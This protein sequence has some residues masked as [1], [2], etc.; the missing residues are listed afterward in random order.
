[1]INLSNYEILKLIYNGDKTTVYQAKSN[2]DGKL[3]VIKILNI[4]YPSLK[5]IAKLKYEYDLL[6]NLDIGGVIK[7]YSLEK[8]NNSFALILENFDSISIDSLI[9][10]QQIELLDFLKIAIEITQ[11]IGEVHQ[12]HIIHKDIKPANILVHRQTHQI[13]IIDFSISSLLPKEK[14]KFSNPDSLEGTLTYISPEQTGRMNRSLDYRTDLYSLGVTFYEMLTGKL[15][16]EVTDPMELIHCH[17][18]RQAV[19]VD[20]L[21]PEIPQVISAI[22]MKLLSKTAEERYQSAF[23]LQFDL[24]NC[25]NQLENIAQI[26]SFTIGQHDQSSQLQIPEKLYGREVEIATLLTAF[27]QVNQGQKELILVAGYSGIGKS[28][29]VNE[30]HKPIIQKKGYFITGKFEQF[31][32][33]I[34]YA[35][36]I[37]ALQELIRQLLTESDVQLASWKDK[38][39]KALAP[40]A[41]IIIDVIPEVELIIGKQPAV[42]QLAPNE[43]QNRFNLFFQKFISILAK[44]EHPL[45]LFLDDLQWA[46]LASLKLIQLLSTDT[47]IQNLLIIGAYRDNEV[48]STHPLT[49]TLQEIEK[50]DVIVRTINC[51]PLKITDIYQLIID[52]F[53]C[54]LER[55]KPLAELIFNKTD[56]NPF[57]LTQV[58][59]F[60]YQEN[61]LLFNFSTS[62]WQWKIEQ[63]QEIDITDNVIE[64]MLSKI[65]KLRECT[66]NILKLAACIGNRFNLDVLSVINEKSHQNTA[67]ELWEA[68]EYGLILPLDHTYK[69][70]QF[71]EQ[72]DDFVIDYKF[73]HDRVQQVAYGLI[74]DGRKKESHLKIGQLLLNNL[75]QSLKE[76]KIFDIVNHL[77][78][79]AE[80][81]NSQVERYNLAQLNLIA[82]SKAKDSTA[83]ES[84]VKF[85]NRGLE[86]LATDSWQT[87]YELTL[88][89]YVETIEMEYL[90]TNFEQAETLFDV[91]IQHSKNI[92]DTVKV[93]EKKI[94]SY[95]SQ[96]RMREALD[97]NLQVLEMLGVTL[98]Q[99]PPT[100]LSIEEFA[101]LP[102]MTDPRK[103]AAMRM[104]ITAIP[105]AYFTE[106]TL[107]PL[108]VFTMIELCLKY[109][110]SSLAAHAYVSYGL[111]LIIIPK[112]LRDIELGYQ[113]GK[114]SLH[115]LEQ[116]DTREIKPKSYAVF[117]MFVKHWKEHLK[118]SIEPLQEGFKLGI[119]A[120]DFEYASY[121]GLLFCMHQFFAGENLELLEQNQTPYISFTQKF[122]QDY[123]TFSLKIF[124]QTVSDFIQGVENEAY[125][126][127][128]IFNNSMMPKLIGNNTAT[129]Y[130]YFG[131]II[132]YYFFKNYTQAVN[133]AHLA[134]QYEVGINGKIYIAQYNFY[135]SLALLALYMERSSDSGFEQENELEATL[136]KV[137]VNQEQ[138]QEWAFYAPVNFQHKYDLVEAE[139]AR[140]LGQTLVAMEY[141]DQA[142]RGANNNGYI[143]EEALAY[144]RAAEFYLALG[145]NEFATL[146]IKKAHYGYT[147]WGAIAKVKDLESRYRELISPSSTTNKTHTTEATI[148]VS[149]TSSKTNNLDLITVIK[150][151]Q[152]LSEEILLDELIES[153]MQIVIENAGAETGY[154][155]LEKEGNLFI[156]AKKGVNRNEFKSHQ[157]VGTNDQYLPVSLIKYVERTREYIVISNATS[158]GIFTTDP[159]IIKNQVKSILCMPIVHQGKLIG[160]LYLE[161]TLIVGAFTPNRLQVL[162]IL[163]SQA[164]ISLENARLYANLE[165]KVVERT[166]ELNKNNRKLEET[167]SELKFTQTQLVQTEKMSSLGQMV[168]GVA[169][170]INNPISFIAGNLTHID[171]YV[172]DLLTLIKLYEEVYPHAVP[173]INEYMEKIQLDFLIE[174][175]PK[176]LSSMRNGTQRI[177]EI[178][179]TLRNFSRLD[180][181]DL[182]LVNIHEGIDSTLVI[183]KNRFQANG[184]SS[185]IEIIKNYA[186]LPKVECYAGQLNQV[187]MNILANAIDALN[188]LNQEQRVASNNHQK[189][190]IIS[191]KIVTPNWVT[192]SIKDNGKGMS[193]T[194]KQKIFDPFFTTKPVGEGT[195]LGLSI[196]Y[197]IIVDKHHGKIECISEL[198]EGA[199][200]VIE[201][202]LLQQK[203]YVNAVKQV[204]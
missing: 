47:E 1:M 43:T 121:S 98:S 48:D 165:E 196:S 61:L 19:P 14:P 56:G 184:K 189:T 198:G 146:Y 122:K 17:I 15:P 37:Q 192:I 42:P 108:I 153:L 75:D 181:S 149:A 10:E 49:L 78:I 175:I 134:K 51:Q 151:S 203:Q 90:N 97:I 164:A 29:L 114:L 41:Q 109:G 202:P 143:Q 101:N 147:R 30:I 150:A 201:I 139:K 131:K 123:F 163:S 194:V 32:R 179:L 178:V 154:L 60:I 118:T 124:R 34:P 155:I 110:N 129:F 88:N 7:A 73:L 6:K 104:L 158:D 168:A 127:G 191:T 55:A 186:D 103:L 156:E 70:P 162:K 74:P 46:D 4:D 18:A 125:L 128:E 141:Y 24:E 180:E 86:M 25:L 132:L 26:S 45:V 21:K 204:I 76:E 20:Q 145:R 183:L 138:L 177:S 140:V 169:H 5:D 142:I 59:K 152:A 161:N 130:L 171:E 197:Q 62:N 144:E 115:I 64:L 176:T 79:G 68:L 16:F 35:S 100:R 40:N 57:F 82:G 91:V 157:I 44:K 80:L 182:K 3:V 159:Y 2:E 160:I 95:V 102:E 120:G 39:L 99:K 96:S 111:I 116:F 135:Y 105:P 77:N 195:G 8:Y 113:F 136:E 84:A 200:F 83:Y 65:Q 9:K 52:T 27:E 71:L 172:H 167:L 63:I 112:P 166:Q 170:E 50:T 28:A 89:L 107:H 72:I 185:A 188:N 12:H 193:A 106:P 54:E 67:L 22:V 31:K 148:T 173:K 93:Y 58:L 94:Q 53:K 190:I 85:F 69:L 66:Q 81:I 87:H 187:F 199:E 137:V 23:G 38:L 13:K 133:H 33:N 36:L 11:A 174:D 126:E 92:L 117:N 119:E